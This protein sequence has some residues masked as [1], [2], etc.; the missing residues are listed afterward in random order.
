MV[1]DNIVESEAAIPYEEDEDD[2]ASDKDSREDSQH[3][4]SNK[5]D[6][7]TMKIDTKSMKTHK[8]I[9]KLQEYEEVEERD[10]NYIQL[11]RYFGDH[12]G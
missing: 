1:A 12:A 8:R 7:A 3:T 9:D 4:T 2:N 10:E 5:V 6:S 11:V